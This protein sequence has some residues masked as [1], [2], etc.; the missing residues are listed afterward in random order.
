M[1][2]PPSISTRLSPR[3]ASAASTVAGAIGPSAA[4][5]CSALRLVREPASRGAAVG[6]AHDQ[7]GRRTVAQQPAVGGQATARIDHDPDRV[8]PGDVARGQPGR[9]RQRGADADHH[10]IAQRPHPMQVGQ[11]LAGR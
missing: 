9:V 7:G 11:A 1:I 10:G 3:A 4:G 2:P 5:R 8:R 6:R